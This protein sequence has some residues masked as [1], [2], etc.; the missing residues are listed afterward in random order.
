MEPENEDWARGRERD[1]IHPGESV[2]CA[3]GVRNIRSAIRPRCLSLSL[4]LSLLFTLSLSV[5]LL[6]ESG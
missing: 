4:A 6:F 1:R 2:L 5:F 3:R